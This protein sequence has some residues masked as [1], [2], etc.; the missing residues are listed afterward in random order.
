M[1]VHKRKRLWK[2]MWALWRKKFVSREKQR[3]MEFRSRLI[4]KVNEA[5]KFDAVKYV[6][7][8]IEDYHHELT[9]KTFKGRRHPK[10]FIKELMEQEKADMDRQ[11]KDNTNLMTGQELI[12]NGET[13]EEFVKRHS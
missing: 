11:H 8:Y 12:K 5:K 3:E 7:E 10:F 1:K 6:Q 9:P 4:H 13:V 2:R